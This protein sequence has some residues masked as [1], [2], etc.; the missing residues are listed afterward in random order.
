MDEQ[1]QQKL[2]NFFTKF[3]NQMYR[4]GA[5]LIR[6]DDDPP[7]VFYLKDGIVKVYAISRKRDEVVLNIFKPMSFFPMSW[8]INESKNMYFY[9]AI[10]D[11][12]VYRAP[13]NEVVTFIKNNPDILYDLMRR[14]YKGVDGMLL[15]MMYLMSGSA[16]TRLLTEL[17]I[18]AKR[19]GQRFENGQSIKLQ[20][21]EKDLATSAGMTRETISREVKL[22]KEKKVILFARNTLVIPDMKKLEEELSNY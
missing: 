9:E 16:R 19:L 3:K 10:T 7:G 18:Q 11:V 6:A 22:L 20:M 14:V 8:A 2:D 13:R 17:M 4:K 1:I 21:S 5:I 12:E 15:R